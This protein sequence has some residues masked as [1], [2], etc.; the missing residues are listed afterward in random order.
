MERLTEWIGEGEDRKAI[1]RMDLKN[2]GHER[3]VRKLAEYEDL[4]DRLNKEF[5]GCISMHGIIDAFIEF[6]KQNETD[7]ELADAMLIV[8]DNVRKYAEW[9]RLDEQGLLLKLPCKVG[10]VVYVIEVNEEEFEH[11]HCGL[12]ISKC[13]FDFWMMSLFGKCVFLTRAEAEEALKKME[14]EDNDER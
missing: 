3:C 12:K 11:F 13:E 2:N 10:D 5:K 9:K 14:R 8:N 1:P 4:E 7:E 6:Y